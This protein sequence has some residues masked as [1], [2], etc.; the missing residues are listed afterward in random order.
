MIQTDKKN[1]LHENAPALRI[2]VFVFYVVIFFS[3][4]LTLFSIWLKPV[5]KHLKFNSTSLLL[6]KLIRACLN[7]WYFNNCE[8]I[9]WHSEFTVTLYFLKYHRVLVQSAT[10]TV[11][12]EAENILVALIQKRIKGNLRWQQWP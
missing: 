3:L 7:P 5:W 8:K 10:H 6:Q 11:F 4:S 9:K 2:H 12:V 1:N